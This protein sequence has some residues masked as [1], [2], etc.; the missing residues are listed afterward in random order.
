[1]EKYV[2]G[3]MSGTS[4]DGIDAA[5]VKIEGCG[6][7]TKVRLIK[8]IK[9]K[10]ETVVKEEINQCCNKEKSSVEKI[11]SLNFKLGYIFAEAVKE[12]CH[13]GSIPLN[14][15]S[16]IGSHGQT[17]Y[18]I[19]Y[20]N[21]NVVKSTFQVG[22]PAI[23]AYE[24]GIKVV[25][26][27]RAMDMAAGGQGA[28]LVPYTEYLIYRSDKNRLLQNI[29]GIANVTVIP[30]NCTIDDV[31]AFDTGPGNMIIDEVVFR[32]KGKSFD[33]N[34]Y[35]ASKGNVNY[36]L[37]QKLM[38][39]DY[40]RHKPP[41]TTGRELFGCQFVDYLMGFKNSIS[42]ND[43]I[44]TLTMFTAKS[45]TYNYEKFIFPNINIQEII[46]GG[47]GSYNRTL[48]FMIKDLLPKYRVLIQEELG[49][50]SDAKEAIAFAILANETINNIPS[51]VKNATGAKKTVILGEITPIP[52]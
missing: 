1:M 43:F 25:S 12:V 19:P 11:C 34:G 3:L 48:I 39:I 20:E 5:L 36:D 38:K 10:F 40:I 45:I 41:K 9:K 14:K 52:Y 18:H 33:E 44:C 16:F 30:A 15:I 49:Y 51:N 35:F 7:T 28:P 46:L 17:I 50:S 13:M 27:F 21:N 32:L 23:I 22:E 6:N 29:G 24:T 47:G 26:N 37:L 2:V 31:Y 8:Y 4:L 42:D